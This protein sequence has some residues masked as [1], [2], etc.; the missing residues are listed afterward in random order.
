V[1]SNTNIGFTANTSGSIIRVSNT[2][3]MNNGGGLAA[4]A[5]GGQVSS[6][7]NNQTGGLAFP[8]TATTQT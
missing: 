2:T 8:S 4:V 1:V 5:G 6:Y 7:G 3:A